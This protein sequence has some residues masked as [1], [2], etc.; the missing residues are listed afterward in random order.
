MNRP[1]CTYRIQL[2]KEF[3]FHHLSNTLSYLHLLG[4]DT[5]YASPIVRAVSGSTHGYDGTDPLSINPEIGSL[6]SFR[7]L[8]KACDRLDLKWVQDIVPNHMA[9]HTEN[10]WLM[11]LL[12]YG[13]TSKFRW[14][15]DTL[16]CE[17]SSTSEPLMVPFLSTSFD[18]ALNSGALSII[19]NNEHFYLEYAKQRFP[20]RPTTYI[21]ILRILVPDAL[22]RLPISLMQLK[23]VEDSGDGARWNQLR[24]RLFTFLHQNELFDTVYTNLPLLQRENRTLVN[25]LNEQHYRLCFWQETSERIN[26]RRF[27]TV[28]GLICVNVHREHVFNDVH[29]CIQALLA[30]GL[31]DGVRVDHIDGLYDPTTY[32]RRLRAL[33]GPDAYIAVEKILEQ[34]ERLPKEWPIQGTTGYDFLA[35]CNNLLSYRAD[36]KKWTKNYQKLSGITSTV[37]DLQVKAKARIVHEHLAGELDNLC[38]LFLTL[39]LFGKRPVKRKVVREL[40]GGFI[41]YF[42]V[43]RIYDTHFPL[44]KKSYFLIQSVLDNLSDNHPS[45]GKEISWMRKLFAMAQHGNDEDLKHNLMVFLQRCMQFTGPAMAKGVEDTL[46]YTYNRF[47]GH[48]E[49]GD[50][51]K[52]FGMSRKMFHREMRKRQRNWPYT[53]NASATHDTKRGEDSRARLAYLS[54]CSSCWFAHVNDWL[55]ICESYGKE[56]PHRNDIYCLFQALYASYPM[57]HTEEECF[58]PRLVD[59]LVKYVREGK[60]HSDWANPNV[61]YEEVLTDFA[62]FLLDKND[63]FF[64]SFHRFFQSTVDG[65]IIY[66]LAQ[67][68][69]KFTCPGIPDIYQGTELWD[70]SFVDPDNRRDV[71]Y[72]ERYNDLNACFSGSPVQVSKL[73]QDRYSGIIKLWLTRQLAHMR[74]DFASLFAE[75]AY[76]EVQVEGVYRRHI[77]AFGRR[78]AE[79]MIL[80]VIPLHVG[81]LEQWDPS[82]FQEF[83]W[84]DTRIVVN[85]LPFDNWKNLLCKGVGQGP[86]IR[87]A[88]L[89]TE[90]PCAAVH[91]YL[92]R[93]KREAG[94]LLPIS[95]LPSAFGIGDFGKG[96]YQFVDRLAASGQRWWQILPLG[97]LSREQYYSP[98]STW[99]AMGGNPL[100]ID[101]ENLVQAGLLEPAD[102]QPIRCRQTDQIDYQRA[103]ADKWTLLDRAFDR[104][105]KHRMPAFEKFCETEESW[106]DDF[107]L[108]AVLRLVYPDSPW[109]RWPLAIKNRNHTVLK[110]L[111]KTYALQI[112]KQKWLQYVFFSQW[113]ALHRYCQAMGIHVLGDVP[114]YVSHD[115]VDV[116]AHRSIFSIR[117]DGKLRK[118]AGVPPDYFEPEGQLWGMPVFNWHSLRVTGYRWWVDRMRL[119]CRLFDEVRLDHFRGFSAYWEIPEDA[120]TAQDGSW[121]K[122][123]GAD[124]F[125]RI[126]SELGTLPFVAEDLGDIDDA[127]CT[128]RDRYGFPGMK[129]LQFAF[130]ADMPSSPNIP[131]QFGTNVIVYTGTHDN[132]TTRG[133]YE[134]LD[135]ASKN[136][137]HAYIGHPISATNVSDALIRLAYAS[138]ADRVVIPM[139]DVMSL[140]A[141]H[142]MNTPAS[143]TGNW[144]WRMPP[145]A[146]TKQQQRMLRTYA[147]LFNR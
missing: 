92:T 136:R 11:D 23:E 7:T 43:Y 145:K 122:G 105:Q 98:Y 127:V 38:R 111:K 5:I 51:P 9:F 96:A 65:G 104:A 30:E 33:V 13:Q 40:I 97:P 61:A 69:L 31:V 147:Y 2:H 45:I 119:N 90:L 129:V 146:F 62:H 8:R 41:T 115:S 21:S 143:T 20:L 83:D 67:V 134:T 99:S 100:F 18:E 107:A 142:R 86:E 131:H 84:E 78:L 91:L 37:D 66:S 3:T 63:R 71:H 58:E 87:I 36:E 109:Y 64:P 24:D 117:R 123:P 44:I 56:L 112:R 28:N 19:L 124:L 59:Y 6:E 77:F 141:K 114:I 70:L 138:T 128:L 94:L 102:L 60:E 101:L 93:P 120:A 133:W 88:D 135:E 27:F 4:I 75:G 125:D 54:G 74:K 139:Q 82:T 17:N 73:W 16:F 118:V 121:Q 53:M 50:H 14:H 55:T 1:N 103:E 49:V 42:P 79:Q 34:N 46:M 48:N 25:L 76:V 130:G 126:R 106:L 72:A 85:D 47:I 52:N 35:L 110:R 95:S 12:Q 89:F 68:L 132:N 15:F 32:L 137:L 29:M 22:P 26:F 140:G 108:F 80:T 10:A 57:P 39:R 113:R 81:V 144:T 116:W